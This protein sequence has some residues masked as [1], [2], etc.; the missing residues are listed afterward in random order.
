[1]QEKKHKKK[2]CLVSI[3]K[4]NEIVA[5]SLTVVIYRDTIEMTG[6]LTIQRIRQLRPGH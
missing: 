3:A 2:T 1:M 4:L 6:D 5:Q